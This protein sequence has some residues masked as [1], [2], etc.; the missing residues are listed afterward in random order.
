MEIS[1][2]QPQ[3][4][5]EEWVAWHRAGGCEGE[6]PA[7]ESPEDLFWCPSCEADWITGVALLYSLDAIYGKGGKGLNE[8]KDGK[9]KGKGKGKDGGKGK[10][11]SK[12]KGDGAG[13]VANGLGKGA[14]LVERRYCNICG[15][16]GTFWPTARKSPRQTLSPGCPRTHRLP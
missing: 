2:V 12:G 14:T 11:K 9:G 8:G 7:A 5:H 13:K 3:Y 4:S 1:S 6:E 10:G 15:I 16:E